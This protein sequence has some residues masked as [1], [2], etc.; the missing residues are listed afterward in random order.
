M[1]YTFIFSLIASILQYL[2]DLYLIKNCIKPKLNKK[3]THAYMLGKFRI[4]IPILYVI[5]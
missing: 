5:L 3:K 1:N 4:L 2:N